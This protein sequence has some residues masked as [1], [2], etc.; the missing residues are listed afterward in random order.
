MAKNSEVSLMLGYGLNMEK[1]P[2]K[3]A[4]TTNGCLRM[5]KLRAPT[6]D[7]KCSQKTAKKKERNESNISM[8]KYHH[9]PTLGVRSVRVSWIPYVEERYSHDPV[10]K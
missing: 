9:N 3:R 1:M 4:M 6:Y 8:K 2:N 5:R 10:M 7:D